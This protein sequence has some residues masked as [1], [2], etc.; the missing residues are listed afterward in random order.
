LEIKGGYNAKNRL[1]RRDKG[2]LP[3]IGV[4]TLPPIIGDELFMMVKEAIVNSYQMRK[5]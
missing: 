3:V 1:E 5:K 4:S 2:F